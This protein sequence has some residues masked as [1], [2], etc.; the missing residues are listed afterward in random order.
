LRLAALTAGVLLAAQTGLS[1]AALSTFDAA[2]YAAQYPDV[3]AV[4][5]NDEGALLR[6]YLDHGIDEGRKPS[7]DGIAG[8]DELSLTEAQ[9][10]SVWSPVAINKLAHYKSL[11]RKCTDE[12]F[13]QAYQEALKVV[14]P[15]ALMSREDQLY[16][17]ASAL[18]FFALLFLPLWRALLALETDSPVMAWACFA[19][20]GLALV[21][22][23]LFVL[24][25][26]DRFQ[27]T[28]VAREGLWEQLCLAAMYVPLLLDAIVHLVSAPEL[29]SPLHGILH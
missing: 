6:H 15:L 13:A 5:G 23:T 11:K 28:A 21:F 9:F 8:D 3:A 29:Y 25:D 2:Y 22:F 4:C 19:A 12:E 26:K 7:A 27:G 18:G 10:S 16:G 17:I 1:A 20:L 14:T 24:S